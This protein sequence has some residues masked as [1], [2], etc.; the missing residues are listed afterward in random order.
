MELYKW[1]KGDELPDRECDCVVV[2]KHV[3][4]KHRNIFDMRKEIGQ[5]FLGNLSDAVNSL[6]FCDAYGSV[7]PKDWIIA[8]MPIEFPKE[9]E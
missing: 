4:C 9:V 3:V 2:W 6:G 8:Y 5:V 1:Y 7:I